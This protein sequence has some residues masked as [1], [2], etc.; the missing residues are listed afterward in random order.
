MFFLE[1]CKDKIIAKCSKVA[2]KDR[3]TAKIAKLTNDICSIESHMMAYAAEDIMKPVATKWQAMSESEA[4]NVITAINDVNEVERIINIKKANIDRDSKMYPW[5]INFHDENVVN[6]GNTLRDIVYRW[7]KYNVGECYQY[8]EF[9]Q[10]Q[11]GTI[12]KKK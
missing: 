6:H 1:Q 12:R 11:Y 3:I 7:D 8:E 9:S 10:R 2:D 5:M 4:L